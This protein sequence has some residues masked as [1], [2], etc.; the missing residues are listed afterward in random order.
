MVNAFAKFLK[1]NRTKPTPSTPTV[2]NDT[3]PRHEA[4]AST[5]TSQFK[6]QLSKF[7]GNVFRAY[8]LARYNLC[9][10]IKTTSFDV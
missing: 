7:K 4:A 1:H 2:G 3:G 8:N 5:R 9:N 10:S 6:K